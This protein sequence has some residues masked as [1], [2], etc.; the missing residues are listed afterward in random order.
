MYNFNSSHHNIEVKCD[1]GNSSKTCKMLRD[2][3]IKTCR[4]TA[5]VRY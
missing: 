3:V 2:P 1:Y 5:E 4:C